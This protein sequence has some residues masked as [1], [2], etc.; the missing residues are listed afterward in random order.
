MRERIAII[1]IPTLK[2]GW[3][4]LSKLDS[5]RNDLT[6]LQLSF[7][8]ETAERAWPPRIQ[9]RMENPNALSSESRLGTAVP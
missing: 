9:L 8:F 2:K 3:L 1:T 5:A 6:C 4:H 7:S